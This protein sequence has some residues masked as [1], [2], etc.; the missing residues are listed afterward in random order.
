MLTALSIQARRRFTAPTKTTGIPRPVC[1]YHAAQALCQ[2]HNPG[3]R[4]KNNRPETIDGGP[5]CLKTMFTTH[6]W[7]AQQQTGEIT[8]QRHPA[9]HC[10]LAFARTPVAPYSP[11][12]PPSRPSLP[13]C[14]KNPEVRQA[15]APMSFPEAGNNCPSLSNKRVRGSQSALSRRA[16]SGGK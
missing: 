5:S 16:R 6:I 10:M 12:N 15:R 2:R 9:D 4:I 11:I 7:Q 1:H 13:A 8:E 3:E 14:R